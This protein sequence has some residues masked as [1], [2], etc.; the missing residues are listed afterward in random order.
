MDTFKKAGWRA[1]GIS[2]MLMERD[3][4]ELSKTGRG[5]AMA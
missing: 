4:R 1:W 2:L 3:M 5:Q